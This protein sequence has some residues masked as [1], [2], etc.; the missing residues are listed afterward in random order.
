MLQA[1]YE[2]EE[3]ELDEEFNEEPPP[4]TS[5]FSDMLFANRRRKK[6]LAREVSTTEYQAHSVDQSDD[7]L[8]VR[9][10]ASAIPQINCKRCHSAQSMDQEKLIREFQSFLGHSEG[11]DISFLL[12]CEACGSTTCIGCGSTLIN[13][14]L[15]FGASARENKHFTWHCDRGRL[16]LIW[17]FL[18]GYDNKAK[19]N[20]CTTT[21]PRKVSP[22]AKSKH[23]HH[24]WGHF[25]GGKHKALAKGIGYAPDGEDYDEDEYYDEFHPVP[26]SAFVGKGVDLNGN[27]T[28]PAAERSA[29]TREVDP[30]DELTAQVMS[31]L[32]AI[33][34]S[35]DN[36]V[37]TEFDLEPP[38][39]LASMLLR[40]SILDKAAELLRND[41]LEDA[42]ARYALYDNLIH[43]LRTLAV[44]SKTTIEVLFTDRAINK[45][46]HSLFK[47]S[48]GTPTR[49]KDEAANSAAPIALCMAN[50]SSQSSMMLKNAHFHK[51]VLDSEEGQQLLLLCNNIIECNTEL[52]TITTR[53]AGK[54]K[55]EEPPAEDKD[56]WQK[57]LAILEV[58]DEE[59]LSIHYS[60]KEA[61]ACKNPATG[62]MRQLIKEI[63]N[64]QTSLPPGIFVRYG[65]S[66]LDVMKVLIVGP[67]GTPYE[68]GLFE[69]DV[70]CP[71][72]YPNAPPQVHIKTT[73]GGR[74][75][76]N[77]NL[78]ADG[79][80]CLS[81]LNTWQGQQ[82]T[83]G[84]STIL[85][86]LVSIQAM[87]FCDE[88]H[89][90]EPGFE[91]DAG[92]DRSKEY[93]RNLYPNVIR[94]AMLEWLTGERSVTPSRT[95]FRRYHPEDFEDPQ[96]QAQFKEQAKNTST[97]DKGGIWSAVVKKHFEVNEKQIAET[98]CHWINDRG[99]ARLKKVKGRTLAEAAEKESHKEKAKSGDKTEPGDLRGRD[100]AGRL[101]VA[102]EEFPKDRRM[103]HEFLE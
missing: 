14:S 62:R 69:F 1:Q 85:Q 95:D 53:R 47:I 44:G 45:G 61:R 43:F 89:C 33:L 86:V 6:K 13:E 48:Y 18:C 75:R 15:E 7:A 102:L 2:A 16:A 80:V 46:G 29:D 66:R 90:N 24:V 56:A 35:L 5:A 73:G 103:P 96:L 21:I 99:P 40:S 101:K 74:Y 49:M 70:F 11:G 71:E 98:V 82:W 83:P 52:Q 84:Q 81:L 36:F 38:V 32:A 92:T 22:S 19:H 27:I 57:D 91:H 9:S 65:E 78:Y 76:F 63:T 94:Y 50:L 51:A 31:A 67:K 88:P 12:T 64:L 87:I 93:S 10:Y 42:T 30:D 8:A 23:R 79:K 41:S 4:S 54:A 68:N 20:K 17:F 59:I 77:P 58:S 60:A 55:A 28:P 97:V 26:A 3:A 34:P 37:P 39:L 72:T 25:R 100:L